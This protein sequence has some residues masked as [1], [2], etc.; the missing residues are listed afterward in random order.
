MNASSDAHSPELIYQSENGDAWY[1]ETNPA[2]DRI[3]VLHRP[4]PQSG[5][6]PR[7]IE[8]EQFLGDGASGPEHQALRDLIAT[9]GNRRTILVACDIHPPQS[10]TFDRFTEAVQ[11]LGAWWHHLETIW[12]IRTALA[13]EN[14]RGRLTAHLGSGDQL[15]VLDITGDAAE[16]VGINRAGVEWLSENLKAGD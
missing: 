14:I 12:L 8:I 6:Q 11:S 4:N 16:C 9:S 15:L 2:T 5:G 1:V 3:A 10:E 7:Y 13:P